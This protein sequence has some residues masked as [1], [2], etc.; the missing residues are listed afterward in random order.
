VF[1]GISSVLSVW[2]V[3]IRGQ[4]LL[5]FVDE[6]RDDGNLRQDSKGNV[7]EIAD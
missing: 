6:G 4:I 1:L 3:L 2:I 7:G 5:S